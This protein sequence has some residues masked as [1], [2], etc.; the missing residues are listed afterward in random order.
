L[1]DECSDEASALRRESQLLRVLRPRFNT[2]NVFPQ[3]SCF[4]GWTSLDGGLEMG[5]STGADEFDRTY[6]AFKSLTGLAFAS[7]LR[8]LWSVIHQPG[9]PHEFP[10]RL[11]RS[12]APRR[13]RFDATEV[14]RTGLEFPELLD[15]FLSGHSSVLLDWLRSRLP[16]TDHS[17]QF[18]RAFLNA[19]LERLQ[20]FYERGPSRN[21]KLR[22]TFGLSGS[23]IPP[24]ELNDLL[25]ACP[26]KPSDEVRPG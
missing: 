7:L 20:E 21:L 18:Q 1:W 14:G 9:S 22:R 23:L 8:L 11:L 13:H 16:I 2:V 19:D 26:K 3:A 5:L 15:D 10:A 17:S 12:R 4:V 24:D 6:G 25:A